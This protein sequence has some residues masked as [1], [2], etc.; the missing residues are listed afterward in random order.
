MMKKNKSNKRGI[1]FLVGAGPWDPGLISVRGAALLSRADVVVYDR[2]V[3]PEI[4]EFAPHAEKIY[5]GKK[6]IDRKESALLRQT[7][8]NRLMFRLALKGKMVVRLK[9]G[10]PL[11]FGRGGEEATYL[12]HHRI[13]YEIVPGVTAGI[14]APAYAGIPVTDRRKASLVTFVTAH[15]KEDQT[16]QSV[17]WRKLAAIE[18]TLVLF[19]GV[20]RI[21]DITQRLIREGKP[22]KTPVSV[23]QEATHPNQRIVEGN[24]KTIAAKVKQARIH[25]P[26]VIVIGEVN[27]FRREL[28]WFGG[29]HRL[30]ISPRR[31]NKKRI[32]TG[33]TVLV[34]RASAQAGSL[35]NQLENEGAKV[36]EFPVI[37][38]LP[39]KS[40]KPLD[41]AI[42]RISEFDWIL[43]TSVNGVQAFMDRLK[44][45]RKDARGLKGV[46]IASIGKATSEMLAIGGIRPDLMPKKFTS[47]ALIQELAR[48]NQIRNKKFLLPRTDIAPQDLNREIE[49]R[50]GTVTQV[51]AYRTASGIAYEKEKAVRQYL[52]QKRIDY[53]TFTSASTVRHFFEAV[54]AAKTDIRKTRLISIGPVT[55]QTLKSFGYRPYREAKEHTTQ[56]LVKVIKNGNA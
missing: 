20:Q 15:E 8:N 29:K 1:V 53:V 33:K 46:R 17:D 3:N 24:L 55:T 34:T 42:Q 4:L 39:P 22:A 25:P 49:K 47:Q 38:I 32:L 7:E 44:V 45:R 23:I 54:K 51:V 10:D 11:V 18:G 16:E 19:M 27:Q 6:S 12:K 50:G 28:S 26:A 52:R 48:R 5:V 35:K 36:I 31:N 40:F 30:E 41:R 56:G 2:L 13:P 21:S 37:E 14:A 43:F 9:G